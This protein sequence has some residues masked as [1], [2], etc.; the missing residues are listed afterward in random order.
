MS[1]LVFSYQIRG[2]QVLLCGRG[3]RKLSSSSSAPPVE[4]GTSFQL[5]ASIHINHQVIT[6]MQ[7]FIFFLNL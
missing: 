1:Q 2:N 6:H 4:A 7:E 3:T 5:C